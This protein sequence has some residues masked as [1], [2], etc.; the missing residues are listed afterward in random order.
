MIP[1]GVELKELLKAWIAISVAFT[2]L[3]RGMDELG[4]V[5]T[6]FL[7][8]LTVGL[9]FL[10]HEL[11]HK[12]VAQHYGCQAEFRANNSMLA[13]AVGLS[14]VGFVFAAPGAVMIKGFLTKKQNGI[15]SIAGPMTN[16]FL[17]F[18]FLPLGFMEGLLGAMGV[19][20]FTINSWLG[21]FNMIPVYP[22]DGAKVWKWNKALYVAVAGILLL[23]VFSGF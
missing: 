16:L 12:I 15:I 17:A 7:S 1:S 13:L 14:F 20:G 8:L 4:I 3:L 11:A 9:G 10:L 19:Y 22:L 6:F 5:A 2:I 18:F 21:L 23:M